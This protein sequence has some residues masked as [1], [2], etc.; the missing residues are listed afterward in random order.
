[1][2]YMHIT[3]ARLAF[4]LLEHR[5][6]HTKLLMKPLRP[7]SEKTWLLV[8]AQHVVARPWT[9][10]TVREEQRKGCGAAW[11]GGLDVPKTKG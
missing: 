11:R 4:G 3:L 1:M 8:A 7:S 6:M 5:S 2:L 9:A 10:P